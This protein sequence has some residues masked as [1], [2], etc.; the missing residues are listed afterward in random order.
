[1]A[2]SVVP[3]YTIPICNNKYISGSELQCTLETWVASEQDIALT[4]SIISDMIT[5]LGKY[6]LQKNFNFIVG[7]VV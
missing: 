1:M 4:K 2:K 3:I 7:F 6:V 5:V